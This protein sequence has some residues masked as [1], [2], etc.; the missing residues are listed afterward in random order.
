[1]RIISQKIQYI[2]PI[3][4]KS[5]ACLCGICRKFGS[6]IDTKANSVVFLCNVP[7]NAADFTVEFVNV[8]ESI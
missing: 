2:V 8:S 4:P 7:I 6:I 5:F 3:L 1:M